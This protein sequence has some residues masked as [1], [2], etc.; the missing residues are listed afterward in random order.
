MEQHNRNRSIDCQLF[1][2][3]RKIIL[4]PLTILSR[5]SGTMGLEKDF[6]QI[7]SDETTIQVPSK[8]GK[9]CQEGWQ[10]FLKK[11][12]R[13]RKCIT[14]FEKIGQYSLREIL[15]LTKKNVPYFV[16]LMYRFCIVY[17]CFILTAVY[18]ISQLIWIDLVFHAYFLL[19]LYIVQSWFDIYILE[20]VFSNHGNCCSS[21][22][23]SVQILGDFLSLV[24]KLD[25]KS[26]WFSTWDRSL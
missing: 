7:N 2:Q 5:S 14:L 9:S 13:L 21:T 17:L 1:L 20:S 10:P 24:S 11:I 18:D 3:I 26:L 4:S 16:H 12:A 6:W 23:D 19:P 25:E 8:I 22:T 15:I